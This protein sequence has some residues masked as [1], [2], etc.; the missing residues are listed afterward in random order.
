MSWYREADHSKD[1]S[2]APPHV[3]E[4]KLDASGN[5]VSPASAVSGKG[6]NGGKPQDGGGSGNLN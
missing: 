5:Y 1:T 6:G 3:A 2:Y 4:Q